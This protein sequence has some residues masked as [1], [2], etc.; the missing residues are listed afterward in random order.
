MQKEILELIKKADPAKLAAIELVIKEYQSVDAQK[1][2]TSER[3]I[4]ALKAAARIL[5]P[6]KEELQGDLLQKVMAAAGMQLPK[7][8]DT[9]SQGG[10]MEEQELE[11]GTQSP[12]PI[13]EEHMVEA[14]KAAE[15]AMKAALQKLGYQKYPEGKL[16]M[17]SGDDMEDMEDVDSSDIS[18]EQVEIEISK[19]HKQEVLKADGTLNLEAVPKALRPALESV[20]K[21]QKDLVKKNASLSKELADKQAAEEKREIVA[22]ADSLTHLGLPKE[23]VIATLQDAKKMGPEAFARISKSYEALNEQN[24]SGK[25]FT[26][27]GSSLSDSSIEMPYEQIEKAAMT[28][29]AKSGVS[30]SKEEA[31]ALF[32]ETAEGQQMYGQYKASRKG[33]I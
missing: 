24:K 32:L 1:I 27:I 17:K 14:M 15:D 22:K 4:A 9:I 29:I 18:D 11:K 30:K 10:K 7:E 20:F 21:A 31:V 12:S 33:G 5:T 25:L 16:H 19:S 2:S 23:D 13:K 8:P 6:F 26:E 28:H 3:A